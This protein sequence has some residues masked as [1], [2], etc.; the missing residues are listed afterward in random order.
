M[1]KFPIIITLFLTILWFYICWYWY[2]CQIKG[3]C[4]VEKINGQIELE[5][6]GD[7]IDDI[8]IPNE[9]INQEDITNLPLEVTQSGIL[10]QQVQEEATPQEDVSLQKQACGDIITQAIS[11]WGNNND[12]EV[13]SLETFLNTKEGEN[14]D[15]N[16]RYN[17][18]D[19]DAVKRFQL[20]YRADVLDPSGI[21]NPTGYVY[22]NTIKKINALNCQ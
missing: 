22:T 17:Q 10:E 20:K 2:T 7:F 11:L 5:S 6:S 4:Y 21:A 8:I 9:T 1:K 19:F 3:F 12:E 15:L 18:D 13:L 14:L 16:G